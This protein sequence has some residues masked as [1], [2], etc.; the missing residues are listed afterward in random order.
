MLAEE[1]SGSRVQIEAGSKVGNGQCPVDEEK[2]TFLTE[3]TNSENFNFYGFF[4]PQH[5]GH[6]HSWSTVFG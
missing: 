4:V 2:V 3:K 6:I 5:L 1:G